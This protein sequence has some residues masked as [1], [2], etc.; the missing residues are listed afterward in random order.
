MGEHPAQA[1]DSI[2]DEYLVL[3]I[4]QRERLFDELNAAKEAT[5]WQRPTASEWS[6][7]E[8]L[9]HLRVIHKSFLRFLRLAWFVER[10]L[11]YLRRQRGYEVTIDDVYRRPNFPMQVGWLWPPYYKPE[12]PTS[13]EQLYAN[14][15][16][17]HKALEHFFL[18]KAPA[19]LGQVVLFDPVI[20]WLNLIQCLRVG[21]YHDEL[22]FEEIRSHLHRL[23]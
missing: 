2:V 1:D 16:E 3:L 23:V 21:I 18:P 10:P 5:I 15:V 11:A 12:R 6:I 8:H 13:R 22:H 20:G 17:W 9:D 4:R 19:L 7:G 14:L